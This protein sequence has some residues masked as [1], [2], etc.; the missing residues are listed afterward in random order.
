MRKFSFSAIL[1][2]IYCTLF[3]KLLIWVNGLFWK[4]DSSK[5]IQKFKEVL[6]FLI[7]K[8]KLRIWGIEGQFML[9]INR[10]DFCFCGF[11]FEN[12]CY[13]WFY[14]EQ[15]CGRIF[16]T[17]PSL[18]YHFSVEINGA[19]VFSINFIIFVFRWCQISKAS[20]S[21]W[22]IPILLYSIWQ[23]LFKLSIALVHWL[24]REILAE[25]NELLIQKLRV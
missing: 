4:T 13:M 20:V 3:W 25:R 18:R 1:N 17:N 16:Q 15:C 2:Q 5:M 9:N 11:Q 6:K 23:L 19:F 8:L 7:Q 10:T 24:W 12:L 22:L 21:I 14:K